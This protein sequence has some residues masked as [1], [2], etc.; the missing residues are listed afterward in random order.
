MT[1]YKIKRLTAAE[2]D[3]VAELE[4]LCFCEPW[5]AN[6]LK[7]LTTP[8]AIGF[9]C[10]EGKRAV[11]YGGML[12]APDEG[13]ITNIAVAPDA[14]RRGYGRAILE[15][16]IQNAEE[17]SLEQ[18]SLE[19]RKS[20]EAAIA[21]YEAFGFFVAGVRKNFYKHPIENGLVMLKSLKEDK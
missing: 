1:D 2:L 19:V 12:Y 21:L 20:N 10:M 15:A 16:L 8:D 6:A 4:A 11:A 5:S 7:L 9:V 3:A 18:I 14:R 17:K 13:Q